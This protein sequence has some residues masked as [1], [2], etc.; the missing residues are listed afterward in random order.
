M[1]RKSGTLLKVRA[2][3]SAAVARTMA[4]DPELLSLMETVPKASVGAADAVVCEVAALFWAG[5]EEMGNIT[6]TTALST[7]EIG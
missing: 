3:L 6:R 7:F 5:A 4:F 1:M 2:S